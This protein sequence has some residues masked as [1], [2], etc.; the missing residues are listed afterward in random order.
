MVLVFNISVISNK[1]PVIS[2]QLLAVEFIIEPVVT[3]RLDRQ[4]L[5]F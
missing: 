3:T 4:I 1:L 2:Y 5:I